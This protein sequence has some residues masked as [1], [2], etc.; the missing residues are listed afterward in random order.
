MAL[1]EKSPKGKLCI[2]VLRVLHGSFAACV[3]DPGSRWETKVER[4]WRSMLSY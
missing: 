2:V 1:K 3:R 4:D